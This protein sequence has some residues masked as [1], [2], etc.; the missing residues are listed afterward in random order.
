MWA[1]AEKDRTED[2]LA[3]PWYERSGFL[4]VVLQL[5]PVAVQKASV[6]IALRLVFL[7]RAS[8]DIFLYSSYYIN[9]YYG[10]TSSPDPAAVSFPTSTTPLYRG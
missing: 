6:C 1:R 5:L 8:A 9:H 2:L 4:W 7:L 10:C 3:E